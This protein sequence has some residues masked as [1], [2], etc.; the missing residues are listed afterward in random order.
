MR[1]RRVGTSVAAGAVTVL[2]AITAVAGLAGCGSDGGSEADVLVIGDSLTV[3][4]QLRNLGTGTSANW[5]IDAVN[6]RTTAEG[7]E[8]AQAAD[9]A[10]YD[11][12]IVALGTND[13]PD[14]EADYAAKIDDMMT[15]LGT[16][17]PVSWVNVD[18]GTDTLAEAETGVNAALTNATARHPNLAVADWSSYLNGRP[19]ADSLRLGDGVHYQLDGYDVRARWMESLASS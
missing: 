12:V 8:V 11:R 10:A 7:T 4:A 19:D 5:T 16:D 15:A 14:T 1:N 18:T 13:Y 17:V 6:G 3:G 9:P 2:L